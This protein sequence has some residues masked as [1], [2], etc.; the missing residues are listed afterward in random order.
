MDPDMF[1]SETPFDSQHC[2]CASFHIHWMSLCLKQS[3]FSEDQ[4]LGEFVSS[5]A[6]CYFVSK[7]SICVCIIPPHFFL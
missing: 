7:W 5:Q 4:I 6:A 2:Y 3:E 1:L